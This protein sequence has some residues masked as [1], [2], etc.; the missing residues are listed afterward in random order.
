MKKRRNNGLRKEK[1]IM[2]SASVFVLT[3]LTMTGVYVKEKN[4]IPKDG[5][6][7]DFS[8][9][10]NEAAEN[11]PSQIS[12]QIR[13][14]E[15]QELANNDMDVDPAFTETNSGKVE[16]PGV[17]DSA[18]ADASAIAEQQDAAA[19]AEAAK[20][21]EADDKN[22]KKEAKETAAASVKNLSFGQEE[23]LQW[24]IVGNILLN[25]SMDKTVYFP[26]LEQ[27][28]YNPALVIAAVQGEA[29][30]AAAD[31]IV[32][33]VFSNEEIGNGITMNLGDGYRLTY[34]QLEKLEVKEGQSIKQG[35]I[36]G[37]VA[38]P[39]KY[40]SVEGSN[41]YFEMTKDEVPVNPMG[42]LQ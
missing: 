27:Y 12:D 11:T 4:S 36:V 41:V 37:Y 39:T 24:P 1:L 13:N 19:E 32:E 7:V 16:I 28:K 3:A 9:M 21:A 10:E 2:L 14:E 38:Q 5:Y 35:Q 6:V 33:S 31:G 34:G 8:K 29:I 15:N 26:T 25:Y 20:K 17:T 22:A 30:V 23:T 18:S 42:K 40:Y